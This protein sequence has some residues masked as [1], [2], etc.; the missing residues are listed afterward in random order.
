MIDKSMQLSAILNKSDL[1]DDPDYAGRIS[2]EHGEIMGKI[3][4]VNQF[5]QELVEHIDLLKLAREENDNELE[6]VGS[7]SFACF[8]FVRFR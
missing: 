8:S 7:Y 5:E 1:W 2:R 4:G 3:K 6:A